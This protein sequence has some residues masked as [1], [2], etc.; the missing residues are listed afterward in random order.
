MDHKE[1]SNEEINNL[2]WQEKSRLIQSDP[3]T[4]ARHFDYHIQELFRLI[5]E[6]KEI[7]GD[8]QDFFYR[9][10]FQNRGR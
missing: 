1:L 3:I 10:E 2:S 6:R 7:L 5:K 9:V 8:I 4:C